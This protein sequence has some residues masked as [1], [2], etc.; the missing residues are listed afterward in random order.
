MI[1]EKLLNSPSVSYSSVR[2]GDH[3]YTIWDGPKKGGKVDNAFSI[4]RD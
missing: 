4:A 2:G 1:W 3:H